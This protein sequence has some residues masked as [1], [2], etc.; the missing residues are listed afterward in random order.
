MTAS[1]NETVSC[2]KPQ[3]SLNENIMTST[4]VP[5]FLVN[6]AYAALGG[7]RKDRAGV[8]GV[9]PTSNW[10]YGEVRSDNAYKRRW[11]VSDLNE[12]HVWN[13]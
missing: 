4:E 13:I 12:V 10:T 8:Y 2:L 1:C 9:I 5:T 11:C 3:G 7:P 6:A